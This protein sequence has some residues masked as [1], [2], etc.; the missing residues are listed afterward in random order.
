M[1]IK[2]TPDL[3]FVFDLDDTLFPEIEFL[4]SGYRHISKQLLKI[5]QKDIYEEMLKRYSEKENVFQWIAS[6]FG[7]EEEIT[8]D[9]LL[10]EY[11]EHYPDIKL[12]RGAAAFLEAVNEAGIPCGLITDGRSITQRNKLKALNLLGVFDEIIIS[13]EFGSEKPSPKNYKV[14]EDKYPGRDFYFFGDNTS[15]DFVVPLQLGWVTVC[16]K[17]RGTNIH[18]QDFVN[19]PAPDHI[20]DSFGEI[21]LVN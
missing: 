15:K 19:H 4:Q 10:K 9:Y 8:K 16:L 6:T 13:E 11:R 21:R 12:D 3:F 18:P 14:F 2:L 5:T 1:E 7:N 17:N 20:I